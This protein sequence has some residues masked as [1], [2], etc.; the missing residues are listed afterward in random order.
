MRRLLFS[1]CI[2][3]P[4]LVMVGDSPL[5]RPFHPPL[6]A[7]LYPP[8]NHVRAGEVRMTVSSF[9]SHCKVWALPAVAG[10]VA[11]WTGACDDLGFA[12]GWGSLRFYE[13]NGNLIETYTG[14]FSHGSL[15][16]TGSWRSDTEFYRGNF[17]GGKKEGKGKEFLD[18][19]HYSG[20]FRDDRKFG[21]GSI[22]W[23]NRDTYKGRWLNGLPDGYGE[24][25]VG[26]EDQAKG[27]RMADKWPAAVPAE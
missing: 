9:S 4:F 20:G 17:E 25:V 26:G 7:P 19:S 18:G 22:V 5:H 6:Y 1:F 21:Y 24:A 23:K 10:K 11:D 16:G 27:E 8:G 13:A 15:N 3:L 2:T 12:T 14:N